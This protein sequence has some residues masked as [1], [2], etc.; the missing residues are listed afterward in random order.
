MTVRK[1]KLQMPVE[2]LLPEKK[3]KCILL[4]PYY[5]YLVTAAFFPMIKLGSL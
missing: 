3:K 1:Y 5:C 2:L 4:M